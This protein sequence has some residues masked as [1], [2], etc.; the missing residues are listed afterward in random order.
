MQRLMKVK[1]ALI[2]VFDKTG[3][4]AFAS[5][6]SELGVEIVSTGGTFKRLKHAN[7]ESQSVESLTGF[8]E[9]LEGRVKT[10]HPRIFGGILA[11]RS[12]K[13]HLD[14]IQGQ[15]IGLIDMIV[16][17]LYPF[18]ETVSKEGVD[19]EEALENIDIG[20][21]SMLRAAAKNFREVAVICN[22]ARYQEVLGHLRENDCRMSEELLLDLAQ[23]AFAHTAR[24]EASIA[25]YFE[26]LKV[27]DALPRRFLIN[28]ERLQRLRYG[29]NPHQQAA[30]YSSPRW[31][32]TS[33]ATSELLSGKE[34]SYNNLAD[35]QAALDMIL[36]F[37]NPFAVII[38]HS[39]PCGAAC[40][41]TIT[42]AY[43]DAL[44]CDPMSTFGGIVGLNR[45][46]DLETAR[47]IHETF[48]LECMLAPDYDPEALELLK[49][50]KNRRIVRVGTL[51]KPSEHFNFKLISGGALLQTPDDITE[52]PVLKVVTEKK[53]TEEQTRSLLFAWKVVA[54]VRSNA[55]VL[56]QGEKAVGIGGGQTSRVDSA[57]IALRKA[58]ERA[59]GAVCASDAFFPMPDSIEMLGE[60]GISAVI[61]PGGSKGDE[62]VIEAC[63]RYGIAMVFTGVRHFRH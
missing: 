18:E 62:K 15:S 29:E 32:G 1:K 26:K 49:K 63:N 10:L 7:V 47:E 17:N 61:Q 37:E 25:S 22:P 13:S 14:Q 4:E 3:V 53:P 60:A 58:G 44:A 55:V 16:V 48:F 24:Y 9:I 50:K 51:R 57:I 30:L 31:D 42:E 45:P 19:L 54:H 36:D 12:V 52:R 46:V 6:L 8:P 21:P 43:H 23:E 41:K 11:K 28:L 5:G 2:S 38:K 20:G 59:R 40:G 34:L 56:A 39:T 33:L 35:L 27:E